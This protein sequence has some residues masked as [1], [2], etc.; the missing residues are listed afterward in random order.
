MIHE[1]VGKRGQ[2][3]NV[4]SCSVSPA[5]G[6]GRPSPQ[7]RRSRF[8]S[9]RKQQEQV[10]SRWN[11]VPNR[12]CRP[13]NLVAITGFPL[14]ERMLIEAIWPAWQLHREAVSCHSL[15]QSPVDCVRVSWFS[16]DRLSFGWLTIEFLGLEQEGPTLGHS[17]TTL[18]N[19]SGSPVFLQPVLSLKQHP[20]VSTPLQPEHK[21]GR[22]K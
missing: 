14:E 7:M 5:K 8:W 16:R 13:S 4:W 3:A 17:Y 21:H 9:R 20:S 1:I 12:S 11:H 18:V 2:R 22:T 19:Y 10:H 6:R 15:L